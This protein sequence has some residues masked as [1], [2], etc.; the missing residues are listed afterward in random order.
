[1]GVDKC[2]EIF[3]QQSILK[4]QNC[5]PC[6]RYALHCN[7]DDDDGAYSDENTRLP[8]FLPHFKSQNHRRIYQEIQL[9]SKKLSY[10]AYLEIR[11]L[12]VFVGESIV[13]LVT[14]LKCLRQWIGISLNASFFSDTK[15]FV[16]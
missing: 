6:I 7:D 2:G 10:L 5:K 16:G 4:G 12:A 11:L 9:I 8:L 3:V 15:D 13:Q 1:M 14:Q